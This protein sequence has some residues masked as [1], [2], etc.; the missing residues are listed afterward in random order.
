MFWEKT[1]MAAWFH[2][3]V[4]SLCCW[5]SKVQQVLV[6]GTTQHKERTK[7]LFSQWWTSTKPCKSTDVLRK[8]LWVQREGKNQTKTLF[9]QGWT[10]KKPCKSTD[11]LRKSLGVQ[12]E[13]KNQ[14]KTLF[15]QGW[16]SKKPCKSTD[17]LRESLWVQHEEGNQT[18]RLV[19]FKAGHRRN[20]VNPPMFYVSPCLCSY[21]TQHEGR[22][23]TKRL[24]L[25]KPA[26]KTSM[27]VTSTKLS[28]HRR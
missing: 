16:T 27:Q 3:S 15:S 25:P 6:S 19:Y 1:L 7:T 26:I 8:S 9:S 17:V 12:H 18:K 4:C 21:A 23:R 2:P 5:E 10:S 11:V 14:R 22:N 20:H 13:G 28:W 24:K